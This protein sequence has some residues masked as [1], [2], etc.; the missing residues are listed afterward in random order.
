MKFAYEYRTKDNVRHAGVVAAS[1]REAA[2]QALKAQGI[3][4]G[5]LTEAPGFFN[6]LFGK[7]KRW[8]AIGALALALVA[9]FA[10]VGADRRAAR[11]HLRHAAEDRAQLFGDPAVIQKLARNGWRETFPDEGEAW[12]ARHAIPGKLCDCPAEGM[13]RPEI[14]DALMARKDEPLEIAEADPDELKKMKRMV[15]G[16]KKEFSSYV[17]PATCNLQPSSS[18]ALDY[19]DKACERCRVEKGVYDNMVHEISILEKRLEKGDAEQAKVLA[20]WDKKNATLRSLGLPAVP[21]PE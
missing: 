19:I 11:D 16:M 7:G 13:W 20:D 8:L 1:D 10:K 5:K 15:N 17:Q 12:L 4:P 21:Q 9:V 6:K 14:A 2:F 18:D 3:K